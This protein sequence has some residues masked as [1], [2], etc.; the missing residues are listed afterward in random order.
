[1]RVFGGLLLT[2]A[3]NLPGLA[4]IP[5]VLA[6]PPVSVEPATT[7]LP[8]Q[9]IGPDDLIGLSV[10]DSPEFTRTIRIGP[11]GSLGFP[12]SKTASKPTA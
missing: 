10:Y 12:C 7:N 8:A 1:M 3:L 4:Q 11:D 2:L 9:R 6:R 5:T